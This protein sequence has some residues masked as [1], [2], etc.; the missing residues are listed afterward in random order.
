MRLLLTSAFLPWP[1]DNGYKL[2]TLSVL[3]GLA[4]LGHEVHLIAFAPP[5]EAARDHRALA[6]WC[7]SMEAVPLTLASLSSA[8]GYVSRALGLASGLPYSARRFRSPE[9]ERRIRERLR[10]T[11]MD[12]VI[13]DGAFSLVN[14]PDTGVPILLN[15]HNVEH[16]ILARYADHEGHPFKRAYA[17]LE[18]RKL[19]A[20]ER[21]ACGRSS[22]VWTC[23]EV[24]RDAFA[25]LC[26][27]RPAMVVPNVIDVD[28]Y[29]P[30]GAGEAATLLYQGGLDWHPNRDAVAFFVAEVLPRVRR[31]VPAARLVVAGRR[32]SE[33]FRRR[34]AGVAG[35]EFTGTVDDMRPVIGRATVCVVPLRIGSGTRLKILEAAAMA[36]AVVSTRLGAE[37]LSFADG[38]EILLADAPQH[39]ADAVVALLASAAR[40]EALGHAARLR[41]EADY[42]PNVLRAR[43]RRALGGVPVASGP[44]VAPVAAVA[45]EAVAP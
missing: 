44:G 16:L 15:T 3:Q 2:R 27:D 45:P 22:A 8:R 41:V 40:R 21:M 30:T 13:A 7:R 25:A 38:T 31:A 14:L 17:R 37:G 35:V 18:S 28:A 23:S 29:H 20:F 33:D 9:M 19:R 12:A 5:R 10:A 34:F 11:A 1:P 36:K 24:D 26:S 42:G 39:F 4:A 6:P 32:A 43:L